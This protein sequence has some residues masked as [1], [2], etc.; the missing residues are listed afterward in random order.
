MTRLRLHCMVDTHSSI[1]NGQTKPFPFEE[2][3]YASPCVKCQDRVM[4]MALQ[5]LTG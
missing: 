4:A 1:I 5:E 2:I 3:P